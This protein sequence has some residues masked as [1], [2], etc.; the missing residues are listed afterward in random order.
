MFDFQINLGKKPKK[1]IRENLNKEERRTQGALRMKVR[2][3]RR[4]VLTSESN[5]KE[6]LT[7]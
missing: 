2:D 4:T 3:T 7:L 1:T 5:K 6:W